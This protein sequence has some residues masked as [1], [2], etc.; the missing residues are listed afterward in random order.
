[1]EVRAGLARPIPIF[2]KIAP[3]LTGDEI[4]EIA[5]VAVQSGLSGIVATNTTLSREGLKSV[6]AGQTGG[7]NRKTGAQSREANW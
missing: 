1:M 7:E 3:D 6:D 4:A 2:L 5:E